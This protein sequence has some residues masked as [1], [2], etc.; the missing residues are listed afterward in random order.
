M[1]PAR[2]RP[3]RLPISSSARGDPPSFPPSAR[4]G[5]TSPPGGGKHLE[6]LPSPSGGGARGGGDIK[7]S[8]N[9]RK[10]S[11]GQETMPSR[12]AVSSKSPKNCSKALSLSVAISTFAPFFAA[13]RKL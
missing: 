5:D 13:R 1:A 6:G 12:L 3:L 11:R 2:T 4:A 10:R 9:F 8:R 7:I